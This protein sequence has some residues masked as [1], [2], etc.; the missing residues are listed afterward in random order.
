M[1]EI[2]KYFSHRPD[3]SYFISEN[4]CSSKYL[5]S[6]CVETTKVNAAFEEPGILNSA[7]S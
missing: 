2:V 1:M 3:S 7:I 6:H 5:Y 4:I